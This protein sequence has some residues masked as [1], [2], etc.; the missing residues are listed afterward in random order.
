[1]HR[2][3]VNIGIYHGSASDTC[4][5]RTQALITGFENHPKNGLM[6]IFAIKVAQIGQNKTFCG[7]FQHCEKIPL[8]RL[9]F[10][11]KPN[12]HHG[13]THLPQKLIITNKIWLSIFVEIQYKLKKEARPE[14][15]FPIRQIFLSL[16]EKETVLGEVIYQRRFSDILWDFLNQEGR[17]N[18]SKAVEW[19]KK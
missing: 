17:K 5:I 7:I 6:W 3:N 1:M 19:A 16:G 9:S 12:Q 10:D 15:R 2:T 8:K 13:K 14:L 4:G 11:S 18:T